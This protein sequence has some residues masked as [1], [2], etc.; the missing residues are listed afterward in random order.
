MKKL[1]AIDGNALLFRAYHA[2][3]FD[4]M[5]QTSDGVYTNALFSFINMINKIKNDYEYDYLI[6]AFDAGKL[7]FRHE[8]FAQYKGKRGE[9]PEE[10]KMQFPLVREYLNLVNIPNYEVEGY[11]ADDI[12]GTL[13]H[14]AI[15]DQFEM[16]IISSDKDLLQLI[17]PN[18]S[19]LL[20][21][22]G[23]S[24]TKLISDDTMDQIW[25]IRPEQV[26]D[27]KG[28][29]GDPSDNI[30]GV[31]GV[32]EKTALK[33]IQEYGSIENIYQNIDQIKGKLQEKLINDKDIAFQSKELATI[34]TDIKLPFKYDEL[35]EG[36]NIDYAKLK[37]FYHRFELKTFL[38]NIN[39]QIDD[40]QE[41]TC[42]FCFSEIERVNPE[43]LKEELFIDFIS[44][45]ENY[46]QDTILG[47]AI[48]AQ[49]NNY[50][51]KLK[52]LYQDHLFLDYLKNAPK[53]TYDLKKNIVI[54]HWHDLQVEN[55]SQDLMI[56]SYVI[57]SN[58]KLEANVLVDTNFNV[59]TLSNKDLL[60]VSKEEQ[61]ENKIKQAY[62]L[63]KLCDKQLSN[64]IDNAR[65]DLYQLEIEIAHILAAMEIK[66][67]LVQPEI[68]SDLEKE[69]QKICDDLEYKI[70]AYAQEEFNVNSTKQLAEILFEKLNLRVIKKTKTGYSTDN[71]VLN[72]LYDDHP[73]IPLIIEYRTYKKM[74]STYIIP[75]PDYILKDH[76]IHTIY[77]QCLTTTG[78]LSSKDPN[79]QN[80]ATRSDVQKQVKKIFVPKDGYSLV[81]LDYS[82]IELRILASFSHDPIFIQAFKEGKDIHKATAAK[83]A[84]IDESLVTPSQRAAAK[85][86]NF[87][88]VYGISDFGLAKQL[89]IERSEAKNFIDNYYLTYPSIKEYLEGLVTYGQKHGYVTTILNRIRYIKELASNNHNIKEMG[90]RMA[91]NTPIQGSAADI[92]KL[93]MAKINH[94]INNEDVRLLLQVHD[95]LIFEIKDDL[96]DEYVPLIKQI[97]EKAYNLE[98]G[99]V[100][101]SAI[102]KNWYELK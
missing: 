14:Q 100:V 80:I 10:L 78:R 46:H 44:L 97:M 54:G 1:I 99:L 18:V 82:Q 26:I 73:I 23:M 42:D 98:V 17:N 47:I 69:Y 6:V 79:L 24:Q 13:A 71:D 28:L 27:L 52:N 32:G 39:S 59:Q 77:N 84:N 102:G 85:A 50:F 15:S 38:N 34:I 9:T 74:L 76:R 21:I 29:M 55:F 5:M 90:K 22:K 57:D 89:M 4:N 7:T 48:I 16:Q 93:A 25:D 40:E 91:M 45:N 87:G 35:V 41:I 3:S 88:I 66:G 12:I 94:E 51:M 19:V 70:Q 43:L 11:E 81:S 72:A 95:E 86:I 2:T 96:L 60:K 101:D 92:L 67:I 61:I 83:A 36:N 63:N 62:Y 49:E 56:Q 37:D 65:L 33:L 30:P 8:N 20:P 31:K 53:K 75:M 58:L 68:L 64:I